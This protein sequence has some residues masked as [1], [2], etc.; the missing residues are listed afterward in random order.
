MDRAKRIESTGNIVSYI[1]NIVCHTIEH[2]KVLLDVLPESDRESL[3]DEYYA[4]AKQ[5]RA[6]ASQV[7]KRRGEIARGIE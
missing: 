4:L 3:L 2:I 5:C 1:D 6:L 7:D